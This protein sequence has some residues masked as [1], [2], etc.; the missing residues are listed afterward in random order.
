MTIFIG[1]IMAHEDDVNSTCYSGE[2]SQLIYSAGDDGQCKVR[3]YFAYSHV[4][5]VVI[6]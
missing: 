3:P 2:G 4:V 6:L 1:Q 5:I